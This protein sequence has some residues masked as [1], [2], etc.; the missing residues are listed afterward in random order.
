M[1]RPSSDFQVEKGRLPRR[2]AR[3]ALAISLEELGII[4]WC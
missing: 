2:Q 3:Q 4:G 1:G